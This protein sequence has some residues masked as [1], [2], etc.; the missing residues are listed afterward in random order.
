MRS[1]QGV[2]SVQL[3]Q[4]VQTGGAS[5]HMTRSDDGLRRADAVEQPQILQRAFHID[6][7]QVRPIGD[8]KLHRDV[9]AVALLVHQLADGSRHLVRVY[10]EIVVVQ[11]RCLGQDHAVRTVQPHSPPASVDQ[12]VVLPT[13]MQSRHESHNA[14]RAR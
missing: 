6:G 8:Q 13:Q 9:F 12:L 14:A 7:G 10:F 11:E 1:D 4:G 3:H 5:V 2:A